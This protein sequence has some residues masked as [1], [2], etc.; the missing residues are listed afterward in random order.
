MQARQDDFGCG[1][2]A[3]KVGAENFRGANFSRR[4]E[5]RPGK[6]H[7]DAFVQPNSGVLRGISQD[8]P[9]VRV[10][11]VDERHEAVVGMEA[12]QRIGAGE[13]DVVGD[14]HQSRRRPFLAQ[15]ARGVGQKQR[16]P[17]KPLE[18]FDGDRQF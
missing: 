3:D 2:H 6:P 10:I 9:Q 7:I 8:G 13:I 11:G 1:R 14:R 12:D 4:F 5:A 15:S 18:R 17:A 16:A